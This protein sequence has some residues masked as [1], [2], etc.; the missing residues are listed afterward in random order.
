MEK[1]TP[2]PASISESKDVRSITLTRAWKRSAVQL[3]FLTFFCIAWNSFLIF[4]YSM[5]FST[6]SPWIMKV[7]PIAHVAIGVGLTYFLFASY[8]NRTDIRIASSKIHIRTHPVPWRGNRTI[9][10][11]QIAQIF[12]TKETSSNDR[13][14]REVFHLHYIDK[15]NQQQAILHHLESPQEALYLERRLLEILKLDRMEVAGAYRG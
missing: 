8:L 15:A 7:F 3:A 6:E 2:I 10:T 9:S 13:N 1:L 11:S 12:V 4:W 14:V 5:A